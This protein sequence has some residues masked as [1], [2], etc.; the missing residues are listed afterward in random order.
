MKAKLL[1]LLALPLAFYG[2]KKD[3][4]TTKPQISLKDSYNKTLR[5]GDILLF[6]VNFTDAE[7]DIQDTLWVQKISRIC[8]TTPGAQFISK[9]RVPDFTPT[10]NLKGI[11]EIGYAYNSNSG[12]YS[13]IAGCSNKNDTCYFKFWLKDKGN[14]VSDTISSANIVLL[15]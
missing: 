13:A 9:N 14:N 1:I 6:Q 8:P 7:G 11:I 15:K 10:S 3:T 5:A 4:Y 2:C 12:G